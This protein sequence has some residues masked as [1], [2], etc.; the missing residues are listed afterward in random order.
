MLGAVQAVAPLALL[1]P[2]TQ[3][4]PAIALPLAVRALPFATDGEKREAR[5]NA[6]QWHRQRRRDI[7]RAHPEVWS[8]VESD[9][10]VFSL[11]LAIL[12]L[13]GYVLWR[14]PSTPLPLLAAHMWGIGSVRSSW[15]V[16]C[17]HA[18]SHG[19]WRHRVGAFGSARFN[20]ALGVANIGTCFGI[21]PSYWLFHATHHT[22]LGM[23]P[24]LEARRRAKR[25]M[26]T[27]SDLGIA[28]RIYS[29]PS[30]R[31]AV[32]LSDAGDFTPRV[33]ELRFQ[34]LSL[35]M[36]LLA[37]LLFLG[38]CGSALLRPP[39][40]DRSLRL[41]LAIQAACSLTGWALVVGVCA[42][43]RSAAPFGFFAGSQLLYLSPLNPNWIW[44]C[45]HTCEQPRDARPESEPQ[46]TVSFYTPD[47]PLGAAL[48]AYMG[49]ENY[50][51]EHHDFSD[52]PMYRLPRLRAIAPEFYGE[53]LRS[54]PLLRLSTWRDVMF[55]TSH[56][57]CQDAT[58]GQAP[59]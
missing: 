37:P 20:A 24:L 52:V 54:R 27:D 5:F 53:S 4:R 49:Y 9:F 45:P 31:Y 41:S 14:S 47:N 6:A 57:A 40:G 58:F 42:A 56:Y 8:L 18:I 46:P 1:A 29:P 23:Y 2:A 15:A 32:A 19:R 11:G 28:S 35:L 30:R 55:G 33:N 59:A 25:G 13:F 10:W 16:Y 3:L 22:H 17:S 21:L 12:P 26:Q 34:A 48:D 39:G 36:H 44:T 50:H 7:L 43:T 38:Y 51:L